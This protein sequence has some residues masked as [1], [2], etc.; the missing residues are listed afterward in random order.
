[1]T[2]N[3]RLKIESRFAYIS[4]E[5]ALLRQ[6]IDRDLD[7]AVKTVDALAAA[8]VELNKARTGFNFAAN[9]KNPWPKRRENEKL[10]ESALENPKP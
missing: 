4:S 7:K 3:Q 2:P 10:S 5:I 1:M 9:W 8:E 6:E